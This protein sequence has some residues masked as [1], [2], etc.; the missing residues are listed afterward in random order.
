MPPRNLDDSDDDDIQIQSDWGGQL[1]D[2]FDKMGLKKSL[3]K[4]VYAYGLEKPS[5]VQQ[6]AIMPLLQGRNLIMQAQSGTGKT[7]AFVIGILQK[8][9][10]SLNA[11]QAL[12]LAPSR[13]LAQQTQKVVLAIGQYMD[14]RCYDCIGGRKVSGDVKKLGKGVHVV[15]GTPG[16]L[17]DL[18]K[19]GALVTDKIKILCL[20]EADEMFSRGFKKQILK[21]FELLPQEGMQVVLLSATFPDAFHNMTKVIMGSNPVKILVKRGQLTLEG[22]KQFFIIMEKPDW[23]LDTLCDLYTTETFTHPTV[24]FCNSRKRVDAL[25]VQL[26][27]RE[28]PALATHGKKLQ[29]DREAHLQDFRTGASRVLIATDMLARGIDVQQVAVVINYDLPESKEMYMHR[30]GRGGRFGR[31]GIAI[32][33]V[34]KEEISKI[35]EIEQYYSTQVEE[36]PLDISILIRRISLNN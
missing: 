27:E 26:E 1:T 7:A 19:R 33:F 20:D 8:L 36:M 24:V 29:K 35:R 28:L 3:L 4:G 5:P 16:R 23:K 9:D 30:I 21:V 11:T 2:D 15:V 17:L 10:L 32:N 14:I 18:V 13:E 12:I 31:K 34:T 22:I 6:R 25:V